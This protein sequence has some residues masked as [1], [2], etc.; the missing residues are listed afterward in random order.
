MCEE[1]IGGFEGYQDGWNGTHASLGPPPSSCPPVDGGES[2]TNSGAV[3]REG[4]FPLG[5]MRGIEFP[6]EVKGKKKGK[7]RITF[8]AVWPEIDG[9]G[10]L[11]SYFGEMG[12]E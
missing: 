1:G 4:R 11:F 3:D 12:L 6:T 10:G 5:R 7:H 8:T 2:L 9:T